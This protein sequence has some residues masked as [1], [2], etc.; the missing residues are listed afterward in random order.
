MDKRKM[1]WGY[2][3][4]VIAVVAGVLLNASGIGAGKFAGFASLGSWMIYIGIVAFFIMTL[5]AIMKK[6]TKVDERALFIASKANRIVFL[7]VILAA[8]VIMVADGIR[9]IAVPYHLFMAYIVCFL[10]LVYAV[11]YKV[12]ERYS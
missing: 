11:S 8:F 2:A 12:I 7:A 1:I 4:A 3:F 10:L 5:R 9:P 6:E